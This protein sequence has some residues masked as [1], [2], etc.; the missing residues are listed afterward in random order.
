MTNV[1]DFTAYKA[2]KARPADASAK[3]G[4][5]YRDNV[6]SLEDWRAKAH[7]RRTASGVFFSTAVLTTAGTSA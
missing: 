3:S 6:V 4:T 7:A 1:I 2:A 5:T